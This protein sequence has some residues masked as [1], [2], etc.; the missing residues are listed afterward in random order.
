MIVSGGA[1]GMCGEM[2]PSRRVATRLHGHVPPVGP[3]FAQPLDRKRELIPL[4]GLRR[5]FCSINSLY[6][7]GRAVGMA[8]TYRPNCHICPS[9][10]CQLVQHAT[11]SMPLGT[12]RLTNNVNIS[13]LRHSTSTPEG[14][15]RVQCRNTKEYTITVFV[16]CLHFC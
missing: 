10:H 16:W 15:H 13:K 9:H 7:S 2:N 5:R 1:S 3:S 8:M 4:Y 12:S 6:P 11:L 14:I